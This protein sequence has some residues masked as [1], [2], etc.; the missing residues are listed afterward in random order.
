[1]Y[2]MLVDAGGCMYARVDDAELMLDDMYN[3]DEDD[4]AGD[5]C[6]MYG[7]M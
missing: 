1:M 7:C 4:D 5:E 3:E 2:A 6:C